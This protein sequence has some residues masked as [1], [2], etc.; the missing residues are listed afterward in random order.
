ME[1]EK[2]QEKKFE[3]IKHIDDRAYKNNKKQKENLIVV[4]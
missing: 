1:L 3:D 4:A 2:W